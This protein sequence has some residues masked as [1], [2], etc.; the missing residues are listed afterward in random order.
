V[1]L[2][3]QFREI[4]QHL[5]DDW[6]AARLRLVVPDEGDC[7]RAAGLL[8]PLNPGRRGKV[9]HFLCVRRAA[10][11]N[12]E[13]VRALLAR[14][15]QERIDVAVELVDV[16]EAQ[17]QQAAARPRL[18][19]AWDE[20]LAA[21]PSDWSDL[22]AE[23]EVGSSDYIEPGAVRLSPL[24]PTRPESRPVFRFRVARKFGYGAS[25]DM[26][27]RCLERL[28]EA[29]I[30]GELRMLHVLSDTRPIK[31]QGP[32]LFPAGKVL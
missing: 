9:I 19:T 3:E 6:E 8:A 21:V 26:A 29:G 12:P 10:L 7:A 20:A 4:E 28:D 31:T 22:Y 18:A 1:A 13:R 24:N 17:P 16:H 25:P 14:V 11:A 5:P 2:V 15:D 32:V 27:R 23:V 30:H